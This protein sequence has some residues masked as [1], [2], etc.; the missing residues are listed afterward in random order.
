MPGV[1]RNT[2]EQITDGH[3]RVRVWCVGAPGASRLSQTLRSYTCH[4]TRVLQPGKASVQTLKLQKRRKRRA[5]DVDATRR[6][7]NVVEGGRV[8]A[9]EATRPRWMKRR[10]RARIVMS[11]GEST[12]AEPDEASYPEVCAVR[13]S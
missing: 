3:R 1:L 8:V 12:D 7:R 13:G 10:R 2:C 9:G 6:A 11:T 4:V 5:G